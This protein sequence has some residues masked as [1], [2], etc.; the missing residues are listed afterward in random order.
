M[1]DSTKQKAPLLV[2]RKTKVQIRKGILPNGRLLGYVIDLNSW[3]VLVGDSPNAVSGQWVA[4][5]YIEG[6]R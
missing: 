1:S 5:E 6:G 2:T 4:K 3:G